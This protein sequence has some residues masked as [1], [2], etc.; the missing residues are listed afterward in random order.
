ME[1]PTETQRQV[2]DKGES[3]DEGK[4]ETSPHVEP[5]RGLLQAKVREENKFVKRS[6]LTDGSFRPRGRS[7]G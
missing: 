5:N 7:L 2:T 3:L 4:G 6:V 1:V